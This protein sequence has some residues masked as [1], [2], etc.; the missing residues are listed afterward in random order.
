MGNAQRLQETCL[1]CEPEAH[2]QADQMLLRSDNFFLFAGIGPLVE[3]YIIIAP[4]RCDWPD[5]PLR[6]F[7]DV[8]LDLLDEVFFLQGLISEFYRDF[9]NQEASMHFEH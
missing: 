8:P 3:G 4:H 5:M 1:F 2:D 6:S 9:Y 7:S